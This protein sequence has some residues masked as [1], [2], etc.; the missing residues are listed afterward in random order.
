[1]RSQLWSLR[2]LVT[3]RR[4][5]QVSF[6]LGEV[7]GNSLRP[8]LKTPSDILLTLIHQILHK[9]LLWLPLYRPI[10]RIKQIQHIRRINRLLHTMA[11]CI[12]ILFLEV[13]IRVIP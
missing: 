2:L 5:A 3:H 4:W 13:L 11:L 12:L 8:S 1:M 9:T 7:D 10:Q 6:T